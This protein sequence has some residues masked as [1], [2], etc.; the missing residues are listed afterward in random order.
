MKLLVL[1]WS[2]LAIGY[3][4]SFRMSKR[5]IVFSWIQ[6]AMMVSIYFLCF[7]IGLRMGVNDQVTS[8]LGTIGIMSVVITIF[9]IAGSMGAIF[10]MRKIFH[11]DRYGNV[12]DRKNRLDN[13]TDNEGDASVNGD[14]KLDLKST[15]IILVD[16]VAGMI[17]GAK[18]IAGSSILIQFDNTS[19]YALIVI[20]CVLL[21]FVGFDLGSSG[22]LLPS[23]KSIGFKIIGFPLAAVTG[24]MVI[25]TITCVVMGF[26]IREG[27]AICLGFGWYS[28][29]P[30]VIAGAGQQY[31][32][33]SAVS[34][35]HNV[36][37]ET[38][39]IIFIPVLAKK[40]GYLEATGVPGVAAMDVCMPIIERSTR[41]DTVLYSFATGLLMCMVTSIGVTLIMGV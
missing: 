23:L 26:S 35:M 25:G 31:M 19:Y 40:I 5:G 17:L 37:R 7:I 34:F 41:P 13:K 38:T 33:A 15:F 29:A 30:I 4:L 24:T 22:T 27:L 3:F 28:Y 16:V 2:F 18:F 14:N 11:M 8:N 20:L 6:S 12:L 10:L 32:V 39:G 36:I 9:C 21:F 1:Y